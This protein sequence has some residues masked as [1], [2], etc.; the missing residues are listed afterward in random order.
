VDVFYTHPDDDH[1]AAGLAEL[2]RD[3]LPML[4]FVQ[5]YAD[6]LR[7]GQPAVPLVKFDWACVSELLEVTCMVAR[8][9]VTLPALADVDGPPEQD[10]RS[11]LRWYGQ[12]ITVVVLCAL[13]L[14]AP[15][16]S[17]GL[18]AEAKSVL[19][20][21]VALVALAVA[22]VQMLLGDGGR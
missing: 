7:E 9:D 19:N 13:L 18:S 12:T 20:Q 11:V 3:A 2:F 16:W 4:R 14:T 8:E 21:E 6:S 10:R 17:E 15:F 22:L 5:P 1:L